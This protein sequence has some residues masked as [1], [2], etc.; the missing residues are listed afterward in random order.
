MVAPLR[1]QKEQRRKWGKGGG[2]DLHCNFWCNTSLSL[3]CTVGSVDLGGGL[4]HAGQ[5]WQRCHQQAQWK[6]INRR[7]NLSIITVLAPAPQWSFDCKCT[8]FFFFVA[9]V[10][11]SVPL[12]SIF[13]HILKPKH[14]SYTTNWSQWHSSLT[15]MLSMCSHWVCPK[16]LDRKQSQIVFSLWMW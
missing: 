7:T 8:F 3:K 4:C 5:R 2:V 12:I 6:K 14:M 16:S 11:N 9:A 1:C 10:L 13:Q 15:K